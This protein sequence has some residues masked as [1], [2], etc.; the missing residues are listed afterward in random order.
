MEKV[1]EHLIT[2]NNRGSH[3]D[4]V[5]EKNPH[6]VKMRSVDWKRARK[7]IYPEHFPLSF[8]CFL[9]ACKALKGCLRISLSREIKNFL[10]QELLTMSSSNS[11]QIR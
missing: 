6:P 9:N 7:G 8:L 11:Q 1:K 10:D 3:V 2:F 4:K 5:D